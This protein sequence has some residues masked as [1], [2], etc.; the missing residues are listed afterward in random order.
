MRSPDI[1]LWLYPGL[2]QVERLFRGLEGLE[3]RIRPIRQRDEGRVRAPADRGVP[4]TKPRRNDTFTT[5]SKR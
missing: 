4:S 3:I 1:R 5:M 2:A